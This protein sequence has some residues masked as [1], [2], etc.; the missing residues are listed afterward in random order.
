MFITFLLAMFV[1]GIEVFFYVH[2]AEG[3]AI[4]LLRLFLLLYADDI[5]IFSV[6]GEGLQKRLDILKDYCT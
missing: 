6:T 5:T 1:N 3:V 4:T 2:G